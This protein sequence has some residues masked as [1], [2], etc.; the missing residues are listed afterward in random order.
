MPDLVQATQ[1]TEAT[2]LTQITLL[3]AGGRV[4][5]K[6]PH[7]LFSTITKEDVLRGTC[8]TFHHGVLNGSVTYYLST[9]DGRTSSLKRLRG[10]EV[11]AEICGVV[12]RTLPSGKTDLYV[13]LCVCDGEPTHTIKVYVDRPETD[14]SALD[15]DIWGTTGVLRLKPLATP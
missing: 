6:V 2:I 13:D 4:R 12:K 14:A 11:V 1:I 8:L 9:E 3:Q 10:T 7:R 5:I 15:F